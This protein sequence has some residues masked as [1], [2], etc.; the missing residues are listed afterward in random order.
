MQTSPAPH[1]QQ[2][3]QPHQN[4]Q[5][6]QQ[7]PPQ[8][9][10]QQQQQQQQQ[11]QPQPLF[12]YTLP[13]SQQKQLLE[14]YDDVLK[15]IG[16]IRASVSDFYNS[17]IQDV[18]QNVNS[19]TL[20]VN[21]EEMLQNLKNAK[22]QMMLAVD[23]ADQLSKKINPYSYPINSS[24]FPAIEQTWAY[25]TGIYDQQNLKLQSQLIFENTWRYETSQ[26]SEHI[27]PSLESKLLAQFPNLFKDNEESSLSKKRKQPSASSPSFQQQQQPQNLQDSPFKLP[28]VPQPLASNLDH[29]MNLDRIIQSCRN[30]TALEI[31]KVQK[32]QTNHS[33][34]GLLVECP[35]VFKCLIYFGIPEDNKNCFSIERVTVF[36]LRESFDS[37]FVSSKYNIFKKISENAFEAISYFSSN[38]NGG[39][40]LKNMLMWLW[41]FRGLFLEE[42]KGCMNILQLDSSLYL[43][44]PP[45]FRT[46]DS[47]TPY[48]PQCFQN[49]LNSGSGG[50]TTIDK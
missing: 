7:H 23:R 35:D 38:P 47:F 42:C 11:Q 22:D 26:K 45:S 2:S 28:T 32:I 20:K 24:H 3:Q 10:H 6:Q 29:F 4:P 16:Y 27:L 40:I 5:H 39:S 50:N 37:F 41:S 19:S 12:T 36:G 44:L 34:K 49:S 18:K 9:Q 1:I 8:Q 30:E 14:Y 15:Q 25:S 46:Y 33:P 31:Q 43:Y 17:I 13:S 48:H 21:K